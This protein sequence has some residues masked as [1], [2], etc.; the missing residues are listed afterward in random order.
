MTGAPALIPSRLRKTRVAVT[1]LARQRACVSDSANVP[2]TGLRPLRGT[3][4][5]LSAVPECS[6]LLIE[7]SGLPPERS[8]AHSARYLNLGTPNRK[9]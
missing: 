7:R 8:R 4:A 2:R 6:G 1:V 9:S 5:E 3:F